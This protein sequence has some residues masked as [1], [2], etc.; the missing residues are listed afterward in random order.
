MAAPTRWTWVWVRPR[1]WW[2]LRKP[3]ELQS[4]GWQ[5]VGYNLATE[6]QL[7]CGKVVLLLSGIKPFFSD[8]I[9]HPNHCSSGIQKFCVDNFP[10]TG[11][12]PKQ[13]LD[14]LKKRKYEAESFQSYYLE[15]CC[16]W[17]EKWNSRILRDL[18]SPVSMSEALL[19]SLHFHMTLL[20]T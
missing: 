12:W 5:K 11:G 10:L 14:S 7:K 6:K 9:L 16:W 17:F 13:L 15:R 2:R 1:R 18:P 8:S 3:G 19:L 4:T 20:R